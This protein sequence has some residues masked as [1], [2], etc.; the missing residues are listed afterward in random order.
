MATAWATAFGETQKDLA[1]VVERAQQSDAIAAYWIDRYQCLAGVLHVTEDDQRARTRMLELNAVP[2]T[3]ETLTHKFAGL[4]LY[5][6]ATLP[7]ELT[8][9]FA[10]QDAVGM[11]RAQ[12]ASARGPLML[13]K[14][15][16]PSS[17]YLPG[18]TI[19]H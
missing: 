8:A 17:I 9:F 3:H 11:W 1:A 12:M 14:D 15:G 19:Q 18:N 7:D 13:F 2:A 5:Q 6:W 10:M 16:Q 4:T